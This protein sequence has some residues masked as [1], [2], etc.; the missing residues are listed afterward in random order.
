MKQYQG[1]KIKIV[2][3]NGEALE[4]V[5]CGANDSIVKVLVDGEKDA[6][7][8]FLRNIYWYSVEGIGMEDGFSGIRLFVCKNESIGCKGRRKLSCA[9]LALKDME[10]EV[11]KTK[12][13]ECDF[14]C[15]GNIESVPARAL[16]VLLDGMMKIEKI[17]VSK[18]AGSR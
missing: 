17:G 1:K 13:M 10:C 7:A 4:G 3:I 9:N 6:R 18:N 8:V 5:C 16:R 12:K 14:G 11:I 15:I 2:S